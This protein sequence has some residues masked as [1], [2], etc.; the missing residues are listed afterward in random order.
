MACAIAPAQAAVFHEAS[1]TL[2][3]V[4]WQQG[5]AGISQGTAGW[6][7]PPALLGP[8]ERQV[9]RNGFRSIMRLIEFTGEL[10]WLKGL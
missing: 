9:L 10:E 1:E 7:V 8:Y 5:R 4:L 6:E 3:I 2:R